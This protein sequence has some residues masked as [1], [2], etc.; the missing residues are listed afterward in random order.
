MRWDRISV[1]IARMDEDL[2]DHGYE[3]F[4]SSHPIYSCHIGISIGTLLV[5]SLTNFK[6]ALFEQIAWIT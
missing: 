3:S 2:N 4:I 5:T 6:M 1:L